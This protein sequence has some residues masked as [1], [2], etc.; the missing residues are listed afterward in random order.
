MGRINLTSMDHKKAAS[1]LESLLGARNYENRK[2][3]GHLRKLI[4]MKNKIA[5][6]PITLR[7]N[8]VEDAVKHAERFRSSKEI[9][10]MADKFVAEHSANWEY[11]EE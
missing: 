2:G 10:E 6:A 9:V 8:E 1:D 5:Y 7:E 4:D 3:I 11:R